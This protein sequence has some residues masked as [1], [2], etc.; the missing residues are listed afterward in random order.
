MV[1]ELRNCLRAELEKRKALLKETLKT[2]EEEV[3][4]VLGSR[5]KLVEIVTCAFVGCSIG[6]ICILESPSVCEYET[7]G[8]VIVRS[9]SP[10]SGNEKLLNSLQSCLACSVEYSVHV[11]LVL[12]RHGSL[13]NLQIPIGIRV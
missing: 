3:K 11:G 8:I 4:S 7:I 2:F 1:S 6:C 12:R 10:L 9:A 5:F 13:P